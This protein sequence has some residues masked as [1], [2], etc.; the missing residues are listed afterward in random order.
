M[1]VLRKVSD[2]LIISTVCTEN[3]DKDNNDVK[4][5]QIHMRLLLFTKNTA[6]MMLLIFLFAVLIQMEEVQ[7]AKKI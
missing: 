2:S 5:E 6:K 4:E 3:S 7:M 1:E